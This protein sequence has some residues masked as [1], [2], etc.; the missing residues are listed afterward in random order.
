MLGPDSEAPTMNSKHFLRAVIT[1][2]SLVVAVPASAQ[3]TGDLNNDGFVNGADLGTLLSWWGPV[4]TA[5]PVSVAC[6]LDSNSLINGADLGLVLSN[7]GVCAGSIS[8]VAPLEGCSDGGTA[9]TI[10]GKYLGTTSSVTVGGIPCTGVVVRSATQVVAIAPPGTPGSAEISLTT[11]SGAIQA[12]EMFNYSPASPSI[13]AVTPNQ[14][15]V[16]GGTRLTISGSC[17]AEATSVTVG[18]VACTQVNVSSPTSITA[19]APA[20]VA[21]PAEVRVV[22]PTS[23]AVAAN[24]YTYLPPSISSIA[25]NAGIIRGG[26]RITISGEYLALTTGVTVGGVPASSVTIV[27]AN[28]VTATT[29]QGALGFA[30][31]VVTGGKGTITVPGGFRYVPVQVP[32]WATFVEADPDPVVVTNAALRAAI[33]STGFAWRVKDTATQIEMLLVPPGTFTMGCTAS[34]QYACASNENPTHA[35]TLTQ[36][37]YMGRYEVTQGQWV[38]KF[39]NN[40]SYFAAY[41]DSASRPV[42]LVSWNTVQYFLSA[43]GMRLPSEAEWEY[44][45]RAGTTTAFNNGSNADTSVGTIAWYWS[46]SSSQTH[47]VGGKA[48][49]ALGLFDMEG[50][51]WEWVSDWYAGYSSGA[52]TDPLGPGSGSAHVS[53]GGSWYYPTNSMRSSYR[54]GSS[55]EWRYSDIGFRVARNP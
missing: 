45:C 3:C 51:V 10:S 6:D 46:N 13:G 24:A 2:L 4:V 41:S 15:C 47:A 16:I 37:F 35:V 14:G 18:G 7:W 40:P 50:N 33:A 49:N 26:T 31:V 8:N 19:V 11:G 12:G 23:T 5:N 42:E 25:P 54:Y 52:Q 27:D 34:N 48:A 20:G 28:T 21:G 55:G 30:N 53:R 44:A 43:T 9:I 1:I 38:A 22:A 32:S 36:A 17:L 39:G 29:P